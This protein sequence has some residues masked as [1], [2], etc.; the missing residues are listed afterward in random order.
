M[1]VALQMKKLI[2]AILILLTCA[3]I[4]VF[5]LML[6]AEFNREKAELISSVDSLT[7]RVNSLAVYNESLNAEN[8]SLKSQLQEKTDRL[9]YL[10]QQYEPFIKILK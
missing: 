2:E 9:T 4:V 3:V 5:S 7:T 6:P 8:E 10:E 1:G